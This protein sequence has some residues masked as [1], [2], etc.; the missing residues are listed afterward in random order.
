M[1]TDQLILLLSALLDRG[2]A[3]IFIRTRS[4][5][6][7]TIEIVKDKKDLQLVEEPAS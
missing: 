4:N 7:H 5:G 3:R 6:T 1:T 2:E